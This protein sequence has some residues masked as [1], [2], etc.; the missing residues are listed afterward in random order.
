MDDNV[1]ELDNRVSTP[2]STGV[3]WVHGTLGDFAAILTLF[4]GAWFMVRVGH[5]FS[6]FSASTLLVL[7][8]ALITGGVIRFGASVQDGVVDV[9]TRGY[10][11]FY[12]G[13]AEL[14]VTDRAALSRGWIVLWTTVHVLS[15][16]VIAGS[17]VLTLRTMAQR[18]AR[19]R[20]GRPN[21]RRQV[22]T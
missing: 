16:P 11:Q 7:I 21:W 3:A 8:S 9:V 15:I 12:T 14:A 22:P 19:E 2:E 17:A 4:G 5:R 13:D 6:W 20:A 1:V 18:R 10:A